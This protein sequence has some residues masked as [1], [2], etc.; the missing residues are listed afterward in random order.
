EKKPRGAIYLRFARGFQNNVFFFL[1]FSSLNKMTVPALAHVVRRAVR[2]TDPALPV[3]ALKT[4]PPHLESNREL[5]IIRAAATLFSRLG[6]ASATT[7][8]IEMGRGGSA[9]STRPKA[10][11]AQQAT[12]NRRRTGVATTDRHSA[13]VRLD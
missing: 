11:T 2:E 7:I 12:I 9:A 5:W 6:V 4:L 13:R 8:L 1:Q 3:L 10:G